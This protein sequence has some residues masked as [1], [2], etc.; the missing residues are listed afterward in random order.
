[1][2]A[3]QALKAAR[4]AGI[5]IGID[6]G[7]LTLEADAAPPLAVLDLLARHKMGVIALLRRGDNGR[8]SE[9]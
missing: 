5:R 7:S 8:S 3:V 2:S 4:E 6:G 1:M 9:D